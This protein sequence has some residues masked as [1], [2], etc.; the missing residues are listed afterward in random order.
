MS[1]SGTVKFYCASCDRTTNHGVLGK[2]ECSSGSDDPFLWVTTHYLGQCAGCDNIS[3]A[4]SSWSEF[5]DD[6]DH[7]E[8]P[9]LHWQTFPR[10]RGERAPT[11]EYYKFPTNIRTVYFEVVGA[12]NANL[13]ILSAIG[14]RALIEEVCKEQNVK[15]NNLSELI[16]GLANEDI[17]SSS[18]ADILHGHRLLGNAAAHEVRQADTEELVAALVIAENMLK[19]IYIVP[20]LSQLMKEKQKEVKKKVRRIRRS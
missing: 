4:K 13:G 15:G 17:L 3:Y 8:E 6:F 10:S 12:L 14:L 20:K 16:D 11:D 1:E 18:Q 2:K 7:E 19:T 5:D 9:N